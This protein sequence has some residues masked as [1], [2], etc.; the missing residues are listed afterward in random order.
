MTTFLLITQQKA[1]PDGGLLFCIL[2]TERAFRLSL[3]YGQGGPK[4][5]KEKGTVVSPS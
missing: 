1:V 5:R 4:T 3:Q 2:F